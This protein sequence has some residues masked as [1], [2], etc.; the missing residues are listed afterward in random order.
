MNGKACFVVPV[1][2]CTFFGLGSAAAAVVF[3][4]SS[5]C[6]CTCSTARVPLHSDQLRSPPAGMK[7]ASLREDG[8][9]MAHAACDKI[10]KYNLS[11]PFPNIISLSLSLSHSLC[12]LFLSCSLSLFL[13]GPVS[14]LSPKG[15]SFFLLLCVGLSRSWSGKGMRHHC[16]QS[17]NQLLHSIP[18]DQSPWEGGGGSGVCPGV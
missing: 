6:T 11:L 5:T 4:C 7:E 17:S 2:L 3:V 14:S 12:A 15:V 10:N 18:L 16:Q 1:V 8:V 9:L 13:F